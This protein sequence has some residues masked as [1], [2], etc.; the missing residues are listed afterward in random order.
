[1]PGRFLRAFAL[2]FAGSRLFR[3]VFLDVL[4]V[5]DIPNVAVKNP[6]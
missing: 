2:I 4:A 1:M 3:F 6:S 5:L